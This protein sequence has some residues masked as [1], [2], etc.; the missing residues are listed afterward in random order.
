M[1]DIDA[2]A[3]PDVEPVLATPSK[4]KNVVC[5][6]GRGNF[7]CSFSFTFLFILTFREV[8]PC[9][10]HRYWQALPKEGF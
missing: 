9:H 7:T 3:A 2:I 6:K 4:P 1:D 10:Q 5:K 8:H